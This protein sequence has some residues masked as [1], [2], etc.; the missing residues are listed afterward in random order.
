LST[1]EPKI[2]GDL[3]QAADQ[4]PSRF[5]EPKAAEAL[6][7][8]V[9]RRRRRERIACIAGMFI[10]GAGLMAG[11]VGVLWIHFDVF[12]QFTLHFG[13]T[14]ISFLI[15]F[16]M[17]RARV[18]AAI[19]L[20]ILAAVVIGTWPHLASR[21]IVVGAATGAER[22]L[23]LMSFNTNFNRRNDDALAEEVLRN[24]P[25]LVVLVEIGQVKRAALEK[26]KPR[27][28]YQVDCFALRVC[29][30]AIIAKAPFATVQLRGVRGGPPLI[31]VSFGPELA[32]LTV[33]G[34][35]TLRFPHQRAQLRQIEKL[36]L[37]LNGMQGRPLVVSGDFNATPFSRMLSIFAERSRMTR[38]TSLPTWPA[39]LSL[40]QLA[41]DHVFVGHGVRT[42]GSPRI[43]RNAGS[44]H[45]PVIIDIAVSARGEPNGNGAAK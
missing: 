26:L 21:N 11:R 4:H 32:G 33:I 45:Y 36:A 38:L 27:Y 34:I 24:D 1:A 25:D 23:R 20:V 44:D 39:F 43:G 35:H 30:M 31:A 9:H 16:L 41:I 3:A 7:L 40:P 22:I 12:S 6:P 19:V 29:S 15:G 14:L 17:P 2:E 5:A 10:A 8:P 42:V 37:F 28:P 18:S 13:A